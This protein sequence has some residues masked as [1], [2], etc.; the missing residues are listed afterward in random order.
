MNKHNIIL[1]GCNFDVLTE[2]FLHFKTTYFEPL[3][4]M[5]IALE[6]SGTGILD[7]VYSPNLS[8]TAL[9]SRLN[10]LLFSQKRTSI[11]RSR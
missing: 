9:I 8:T 11:D 5:E 2:T 10:L 7:V 3:K 1:D 6:L 4:M